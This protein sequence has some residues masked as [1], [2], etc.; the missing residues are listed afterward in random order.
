MAR[1]CSDREHGIQRPPADRVE[2]R[3]A[4]NQIA[5][6]CPTCRESIVL[7][8]TALTAIAAGNRVGSWC[9]GCRAKI[10]VTVASLGGFLWAQ[11]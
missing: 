7:G 8:P 11:E 2:E 4:D 3:Q 9:K 10:V 5:F 6:E 1:P